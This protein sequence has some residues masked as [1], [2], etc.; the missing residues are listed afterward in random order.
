MNRRGIMAQIKLTPEELRQSAQRY[1][2]GANNVEEVL[3]ALTREQQVIDENWDGHAFDRFENQF[4]ELTPKIREF[5]ELLSDINQ[6][7]IKVAD[8]LEQTDQDIASQI[9]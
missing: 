9:G 3:N 6:Q 2:E 7:L 4:N 5:I 8:T 1:T